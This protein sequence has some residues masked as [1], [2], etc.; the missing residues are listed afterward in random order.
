MCIP[1]GKLFKYTKIHVYDLDLLPTLNIIGTKFDNGKLHV[2]R[3]H[4][5]FINI[6]LLVLEKYRSL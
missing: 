1:Y 3:G 6:S 4:L 5:C 2:L